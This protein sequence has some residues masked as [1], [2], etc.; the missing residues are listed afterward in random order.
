MVKINRLLRIKQ[1]KYSLVHMPQN[2][3]E[4]ITSI[5]APIT[6]QNEPINCKNAISL[7]YKPLITQ[8]SF[9]SNF[10]YIYIFPEA[11]PC[12]MKHVKNLPNTWY[13]TKVMTLNA[14]LDNWQR[15]SHISDTS[16][17]IYSYLMISASFNS[18]ALTRLI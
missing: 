18:I 13:V 4:K 12:G 16:R 17:D 1:Q 5:Q 14:W 8:L 9:L 10:G 3:Q 2:I 6:L 15:C 7:T 11:G